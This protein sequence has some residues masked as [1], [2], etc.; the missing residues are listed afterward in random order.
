MNPNQAALRDKAFLI[1]PVLLLALLTLVAFATRPM[2]PIDETRYIGVAWEMWLKGDYLVMLK[3]GAPYSHKPPLLFW[4]FNLGWAVFGVNEWWPRLV[5]PLFSLGSLLLVLSAG[6]RLWPQDAPAR[7]NAVWILSSCLLWMLF[8]TSAMFDV[9]L[10]FFVL[11]GLHGLL[12]AAEGASARGFAWLAAGIGFG[13]LA[14]GPVVLLHLLPVAALAPW[15]HPGLNWKRWAGGTLLAV[16]GGAAIA[17]AWA[18]PAAIQGGEEY[19]HMIFWGQTAGRVADSFAHKRPLWWYLPLLPGLLFPWLLWPGLWRRGIALY[20]EGLDNGLR[21]CFAWLLP[22]FFV[23]S[24]ISGKQVHYLV[25][26]LPAFA[27]LAGRLL[28]R[29][30]SGDRRGGD[31]WLPALLTAAA[32]AA[33]L[34]LAP[35]GVASRLES[36]VGLPRWPG[37]ALTLAALALLWLGSRAERRIV[38]LAALG[39]ALFV[40][41]HFYIAG[42]LWYR[43]DVQPTALEIKKLQQRGIAVGKDG[44]YH[45]QYHFFGRLERPI[46][47]LQTPAEIRAW[48]EQHPDGVLLVQSVPK[49]GEPALFSHPFRG[50]TAVL[51]NADQARSR[52]LLQ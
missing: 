12:L 24:L 31:V 43:Y 21:F 5:S 47:E 51:L 38:S 10:T 46:A 48:F 30:E 15:W 34:W 6:R 2:T 18:V 3:N 40:M 14:K 52:G 33:M 22:V 7:Q 50:E 4:I 19:R 25:P 13:V 23:F 29:G 39:A 17:L 26:I 28:A 42:N 35:D 37:L 41:F 11:L 9:M 1:G 20:R 16:L 44:D 8:S 45:D 32:G 36:W 49:P 27:L